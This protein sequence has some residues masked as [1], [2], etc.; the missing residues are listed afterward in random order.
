MNKDLPYKGE[1]PNTWNLHR[2]FWTP[3]AAFNKNIHKTNVT[4][5]CSCSNC[6]PT[7]P[8]GYYNTE[9]IV[10]GYKK[11]ENKCINN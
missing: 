9:G 5:G 4:W 1:T 2:A 6:S 3:G 8:F 11:P 10:V 7:T